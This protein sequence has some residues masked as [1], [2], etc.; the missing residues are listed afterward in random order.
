MIMFR[1][2]PVLAL[3]LMA[4]TARAQTADE[5]VVSNPH[6]A[7]PPA[8]TA[9]AGGAAAK[10]LTTDE[11]TKAW[12]SDAPRL[13]RAPAADAGAS[14]KR[15]VHGSAGVSVGSGGYSSAYVSTL[16]PVGKSGTLGLAYSQTD[17]GNN[18]VYGYGYGGGYGRY[19]RGGRSQSVAVML[20]MSG[21]DASMPE[22]CVPGFRDGDRYMEPV[23]V[24]RL[25]PELSCV[26]DS[27]AHAEWTLGH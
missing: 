12:I 6:A 2:L 11:Q 5:M 4:T 7:A 9:A 13:D 18:P 24:S 16:I 25:H 23:W 8:A 14:G 26:R 22:G 3:A 15:Q 17:Y 10:P 21:Q 1:A 20:D 19:H 27:E